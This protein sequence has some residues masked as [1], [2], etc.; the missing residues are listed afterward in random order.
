MF[1]KYTKKEDINISSDEIVGIED[2][3]MEINNNDS[4]EK[5]NSDNDNGKPKTYDT[6][7]MESS[8]EGIRVLIGKDKRTNEE[9]YWEFG[10]KK[11]PNRHMLITGNSGTGKTYCIQ[12]L[13]LELSKKNVSSV[14]F[15][16]TDG[17][18]PSKLEKEF[19][20]Y[21]CDRVNKII[22]LQN[23]F[24]INPFRFQNIDAGGIKF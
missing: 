24:P 19:K 5:N 7:V 21:L 2:N 22:L 1:R 16:Y 20:D 15:D 3:K 10:N 14:I 17:F 4:E 11:L 8:M 18:T 9:V 23:K 6:A 13:L 12:A